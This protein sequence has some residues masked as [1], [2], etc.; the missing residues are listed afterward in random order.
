MSSQ[1]AVSALPVPM[2]APLTLK[3]HRAMTA[4]DYLRVICFLLFLAALFV[5]GF[6]MD[7]GYRLPK[8]NRFM[9]LALYALSV[10][11]IW[12][13]TGLLSLGQGLYFGIGGYIVGYSLILQAS[14]NI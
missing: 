1:T 2:E 12:G 8:F 11:L 9:A 14:G 3:S 10:D 5:P 7:P 13:Y 4:R 6:H